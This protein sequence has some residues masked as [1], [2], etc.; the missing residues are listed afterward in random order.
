MSDL[1]YPVE[2]I[3]L[4][5][6]GKYYPEGHPLRETSGQL[7]LKY[8]TAKEEDILTSTNLIQNGT[9]IDELLKS[10]I[11][12]KGVKSADLTTGDIN[13]ILIAS[14]VLAY[15]KDY[16]IEYDGPAVILK[17]KEQE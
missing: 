13:A 6:G 11:V 5:S 16:E 17:K 4:P 15:G 9:V 3:N 1:M 12:H 7:E 2:I 8:M 14:R 10:L